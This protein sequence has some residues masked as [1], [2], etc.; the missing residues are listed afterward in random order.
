MDWT[1]LTTTI[2]ALAALVTATA[3]LID[4]IKRRNRNRD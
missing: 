2:T 1:A 4:A 3:G